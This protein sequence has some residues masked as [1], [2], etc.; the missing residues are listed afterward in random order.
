MCIA[1]IRL[2]HRRLPPYISGH[3]Q[4]GDAAQTFVEH[5]YLLKGLREVRVALH[6]GANDLLDVRP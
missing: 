3:R 6:I 2:S 5:H 4:Y 1:G